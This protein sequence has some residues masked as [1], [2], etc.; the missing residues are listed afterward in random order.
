MAITHWLDHSGQSVTKI[1]LLSWLVAILCA[2]PAFADDAFNAQRAKKDAIISQIRGRD[3]MVHAIKNLSPADQERDLCLALN[4]YFEVRNCTLTESVA[5]SY[6]VLN[7]YY[8]ND[9]PGLKNTKTSLCAVVFAPKQYSWTNDDVIPYPANKKLW[10]IAQSVSYTILNNPR[11]YNDHAKQFAMKHYI[12]RALNDSPNAP[13]WS[14][15]A[16][17]KIQFDNGSHVYMYMQ[18]L[19]WYKNK[20]IIA[21]R[22]KRLITKD[23][24]EINKLITVGE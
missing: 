21:S 3:D 18:P 5:S 4:I 7:R 16:T 24:A 10:R 8:D 14:K 1:A 2:V 20:Y 9:I 23:A 19:P 11:Y 22:L 13:K 15:A 12:T 17:F 6:T